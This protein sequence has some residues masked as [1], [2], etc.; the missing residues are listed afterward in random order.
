[1][2]YL[3]ILLLFV[4]NINCQTINSNSFFVNRVVLSAPDA[5]V[6]FWNYTNTDIIFKIVAKTNGWVGFGIS[7]NGGMENS[8][9]ILAYTMPSGMVMFVDS[10]TESQKVVITDKAQNWKQLFY[11]NTNGVTTVIFTRKIKICE[12]VGSEVNIN[13]E[14]TS[15]VIYS[16]GSGVPGYHG[17]NRGSK[18]TPLLSS[19]NQASPPNLTGAETADFRVNVKKHKY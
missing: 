12:Q 3:C 2:K 9:I 6:L 14:A 10:H 15:Y 5:Y 8:D 4:Y 13:I 7:P 19:L 16:W 11:S 18:S 1:M 17:A